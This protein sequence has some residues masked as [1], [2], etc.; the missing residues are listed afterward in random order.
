MKKRSSNGQ[1]KNLKLITNKLAKK[2][3]CTKQFY[4]V[5]KIEE[6]IYNDPSKYSALFKEYLLFEDDTEFLRRFYCN[7][8]LPKKLKHILFFYEKY[9]KIFPNYT[10]MEGA[11]YLYKN[12][13]KK[14]K[15]IDNL[16]EIKKQENYNKKHP[17]NDTTILSNTA[18]NSILNE[19]NSFYRKN[20]SKLFN[21]IDFSKCINTTVDDFNKIILFIDT[22]EDLVNQ[23]RTLSP[24]NAKKNSILMKELSKIHMSNSIDKK[25]ISPNVNNFISGNC[26]SNRNEV[27]FNQKNFNVDLNNLSTKSTNKTKF[28]LHKKINSQNISGS[29]KSKI[30]Q[31]EKNNIKHIKNLS[32]NEKGNNF[33]NYN[34]IQNIKNNSTNISNN[35]NT[36]ENFNQTNLVSISSFRN[37]INQS[38]NFTSIHK[39]TNFSGNNSRINFF[40]HTK[41]PSNKEYFTEREGKKRITHFQKGNVSYPIRK[42]SSSN[43]LN[44]ELSP[45]TKKK[46]VFSTINS[47]L[48]IKKNKK[49]LFKEPA[50]KCKPIDNLVYAGKIKLKINNENKFIVTKKIK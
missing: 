7:N 22:A 21:C 37:G 19:S 6:L 34:N 13:Q 45:I 38:L 1:N 31:L 44:F 29:L 23:N 2:Y 12:I 16:Q 9:S 5:K 41:T 47:G 40:S 50:I 28:V 46:N 3:N 25:P 17:S 20:L 36:I 42:F 27:L 39:K 33:K 4:N 49:I 8:E 14:Q 18:M 15:M 10:I 48:Q 11:K 24:K 30:L 35:M 26:N 43:H 32:I